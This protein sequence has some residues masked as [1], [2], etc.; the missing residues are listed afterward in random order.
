MTPDEALSAA[1]ELHR[2]GKLPNAIRAYEAIVAAHPDH[3]GAWMNLGA[4]KRQSGALDDAVAALHRAAA[5]APDHPGVLYNLGNALAEAARLPEAAASLRAAINADGQFADAYNN[6]GEVLIR[7]GEAEAAVAAFRDGLAIASSHIG[8]LTNLANALHAQGQTPEAV[9]CLRDAAERAPENGQ[10]LRNLGNVLRGAG[11]LPDAEDALRRALAIAPNDAE[12]WCLLAFCKLAQGDYGAGWDA[13][14]WRWQSASHEDA[15]PFAHP[16]WDGADLRGKSLLIWGEQA[17]GDEIMLATMYDE[18]ADRGAAITIETEH[19]LQPL[20]DRSFPAFQ[21]IARRTPPD[22]RLSTAQFDFQIA[23]GDLGRILRRA[24]T[25]FDGT[26]PYLRADTEKARGFRQ[27][28]A[29][30][31]GS[32]R[33]IGISW[34]SGAE[35][36]GMPRSIPPDILAPLLRR[37]DCWFVN[38]QYGDTASELTTMHNETGVRVYN[39]PDVDPIRDLDTAAAQIA[40]LDLVISAA[41]TTVHMAGA[42]GMATWV[43]LSRTPDWRWMLAGDTSPWYPSVQLFRQDLS[44]NWM[45]PLAAVMEILDNEPAP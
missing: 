16:L 19:R 13:Y 29:S 14:D 4:A 22:P 36:P 2:A 44:G 34:R 9:D 37:D 20:F 30:K 6:L 23:S 21:I 10:I 12:A 40:S 7:N 33:R 41:N 15:R 17:V 39:D 38:L 5:L 11:H 25:D 32:R 31:A 8:L 27:A 28:Y 26:R 43:L 35:Q 24:E 45:A 1:L 3:A 18:L 42:L